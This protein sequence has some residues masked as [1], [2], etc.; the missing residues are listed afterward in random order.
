MSTSVISDEPRKPEQPIKPV[1]SDFSISES[2]VRKFEMLGD[3]CQE[4]VANFARF[5]LYGDVVF[6]VFKSLFS[7]VFVLPISLISFSW[8]LSIFSSLIFALLMFFGISLWRFFVFIFRWLKWQ[9]GYEKHMQARFFF[10]QFG[11]ERIRN[12][13]EYRK[14]KHD[15][16]RKIR[17]Y[18]GAVKSYNH[19]LRKWKSYENWSSLRGADFEQAVA[20]FFRGKSYDVKF[21]PHTGDEGID[22][23]MNK[24]GRSFVVQC[25]AH[26]NPVVSSTVRDLLGAMG[27][28]GADEAY[29]CTLNGL[30]RPALDYALRNNV[31]VLTINDYL[32]AL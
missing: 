2:D 22:L 5:G 18:A 16:D 27:S 13:T 21:T 30:T 25:K 32:K 3:N 28:E 4:E 1:I 17:A 29:L 10:K 31:R 8:K 14:L 11:A 26:K 12:I 7:I 23:I 15:Y 19:R 9:L 6:D 24:D 20:A